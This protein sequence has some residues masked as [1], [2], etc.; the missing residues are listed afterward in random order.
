MSA[1]QYLVWF[2]SVVALAMAGLIAFNAFAEHV[3]LTD[4][5][6]PSIQTVSGFERV[7]KP[8]WLD[9]IAPTM[10]FVGS[11]RMREGFDPVLIDPA[12]H[13][14]SFDYGVSSITAYEARRFTED[15][16]A[17][18]SVNTIVMALDAFS[19]TGAAQKFGPGFDELR[20][21]VTAEG[22]PTPRRALWLFATRYLS[23]GAAG[24]HALGLYDLA[25]L[26]PRQAAA[27]RPDL[28]EAYGRMS[29]AGKRRDLANRA[30]R[31]MAMGAWQ[32]AQLEAV[33]ADL[34]PRRDVRTFLFF[35]PDNY[36]VIALY[37]KNDHDGFVAFKQTVLADVERHNAACEGKVALFDFLNRNAITDANMTGGSSADYLDLVHFRPPVGVR[38]LRRMLGTGKD[39][40]G[41]ELAGPHAAL[42]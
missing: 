41:V 16:L 34:C 31:V 2:L 7:L 5:N 22:A 15:A 33:L 25:Q 8:A 36:A 14:R 37:L 6:G 32:H 19:G 4:R 29:E 27:D 17:Q 21:K 1:K 40:A 28:F 11:S 20:L 3:I 18:S 42:R 12:F 13:V 39:A 38:L 9:S 23:G 26:G 24:M 30:G 10:V 35:P